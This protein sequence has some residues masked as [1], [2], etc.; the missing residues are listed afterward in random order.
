MRAIT[1]L[2]LSL[3]AFPAIAADAITPAA[4]DVVESDRWYL[5][6]LNEQPAASLH[7]VVLRHADG[8]RSTQ[9][10]TTV[11]I[12]RTLGERSIRIS[13]SES[14][15]LAED[16]KGAITSFRFDRDENGQITS[17]D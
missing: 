3:L 12:Q 6:L 15:M 7:G 9:F 2:V 17:A 13:V 8:S 1:I 10:D 14:Q 4:D 11:I 5:G 16:A